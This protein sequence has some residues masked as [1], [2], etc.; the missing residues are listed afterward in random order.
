MVVMLRVSTVEIF[1][2]C[3]AALPEI[4][5]HRTT[6]IRSILISPTTHCVDS[7]DFA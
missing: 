7:E 5:V 4:A 3:K 2:S 6:E 1:P